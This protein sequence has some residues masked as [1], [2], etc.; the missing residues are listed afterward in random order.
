MVNLM[1]AAL[2]LWNSASIMHNLQVLESSKRTAGFASAGH[3]FAFFCTFLL[4][5]PAPLRGHFFAPE[6]TKSK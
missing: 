3:F 2:D 6:I 4:A 1:Q 5:L